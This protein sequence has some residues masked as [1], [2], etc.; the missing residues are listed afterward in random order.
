MALIASGIKPLN[1][2][3]W[4]KQQIVTGGRSSTRKR[5]LSKDAQLDENWN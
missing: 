5:H 1:K 2:M 3:L 4:I